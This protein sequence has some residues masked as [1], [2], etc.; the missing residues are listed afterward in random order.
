MAVVKTADEVKKH[1]L[2]K[3]GPKLGPVYHELADELAWLQLKWAEYRELFGKS[4]ERITLLNSAAGLFFRILQDTLWDDALLH[5]CRL[6]DR[7]EVAGKANLTI[8]VLPELCED[9][10][11]RARVSELV[12]NAVA[13]TAFARDWRNRRI[14]HRDLAL[15]LDLAAK[16]L[17]QASRARVSQALSSLHAVVN[18]ISERLL[19]STLA[20][21]VIAPST[22]AEA[23]LYVIRDGLDAHEA[24]MAR[25]RSGKLLPGDLEHRAV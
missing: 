12:D 13:A 15:A 22:G 3:L 10:A 14:G 24:R 17:A 16:P 9:P 8:L 19:D 11:L 1:H 20:D 18:E 5:I 25:I 4:P 23:L 6:T 21:E 7:A 2:E